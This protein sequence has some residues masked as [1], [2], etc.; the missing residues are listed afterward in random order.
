MSKT[1]SNKYWIKTGASVWIKSVSIM[2]PIT[3]TILSVDAENNIAMVDTKFRKF[4]I[5]FDYIFRT[6]KE[7]GG[8]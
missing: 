3:A 1:I 6:E 2:L 4:Q 8:L 7:A 5:H